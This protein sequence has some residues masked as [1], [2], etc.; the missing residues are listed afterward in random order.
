M[1]SLRKSVTLQ[2]YLFSTK[3]NGRRVDLL[4][5]LF[6]KQWKV[7][8]AGPGYFAKYKDGNTKQSDVQIMLI[9]YL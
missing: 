1:G 7:N 4:R 6:T 3:Q 9:T 8:T 5:R 2:I